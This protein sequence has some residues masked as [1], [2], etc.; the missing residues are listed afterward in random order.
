MLNS[1]NKVLLSN[2]KKINLKINNIHYALNAN[3]IERLFSLLTSQLVEGV[4]ITGS[5]EAFVNELENAESI[6]IYEFIK[7]NKYE[8][9]QG[10]FFKYNHIMN[11]DFTKYQIYKAEEQVDYDNCLIFA[12]KKGGLCDEK[13]EKLS[14]IFQLMLAKN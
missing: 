13:L 7:T 5:D 11:F 4:N 8:N 1:I 2:G 6:E 14:A 9:G 12:L 10:D 3:T